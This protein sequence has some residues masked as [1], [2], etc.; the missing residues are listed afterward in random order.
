VVLGALAI[1]LII[2]GIVIPAKLGPV[3]RAW[4]GVAKTL[5]KVTTPIFMGVVYFGILTPIALL[6]RL[7]GSG[8]VQSCGELGYW[9]DRRQSPPSSMERQF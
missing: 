8:L 3:E 2:A 5:A 9:C 4:M 6:R 1:P 7:G